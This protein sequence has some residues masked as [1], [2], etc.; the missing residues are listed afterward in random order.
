MVSM[1]RFTVGRAPVILSRNVVEAKNLLLTQVEQMLRLRSFP[2][3]M[4]ETPDM[5]NI[6]YKLRIEKRRTIMP[7]RSALIRDA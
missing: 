6:S 1:Q 7:S 2:L 5:R 3:S 4:T